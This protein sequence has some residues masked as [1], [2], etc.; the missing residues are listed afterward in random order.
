[1]C[2]V[3]SGRGKNRVCRNVEIGNIARVISLYRYAKTGV[4]TRVIVKKTTTTTKTIRK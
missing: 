1:M 3:K 2:F 4:Y